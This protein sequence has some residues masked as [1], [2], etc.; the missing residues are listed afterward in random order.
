MGKIKKSHIL[1]VENTPHTSKGQDSVLKKYGYK[2]TAVADGKE[3][4]TIVKNKSNQVDL[5]LIDLDL[6]DDIDGPETARR[7]LKEEML[8]IVF[9][10]DC[11][12]KET[13]D[14]VKDITNY[15]YILK[16]SGEFVLMESINMAFRLSKAHQCAME[17][18]EKL[19]TIFNETPDVI[20]IHDL[21]SRIHEVNQTAADVYQY[22][23]EEL[24]SMHIE[25]LDPD[26]KE[27]EDGGRFWDSVDYK[28]PYQFEARQK[29]KDGTIFPAE[30]RVTKLKLKGSTYIMAL[31]R[32][33]SDRK[34]TEEQLRIFRKVVL[35]VHDPIAVI[36]TSY[37]YIL[38]NPVYSRWLDLDKNDIIGRKVPEILGKELFETEL[39]EYIDE[40]FTGSV[41]HYSRWFKFPIKGEVYVDVYYYPFRDTD[42]NITALVIVIRDITGQKKAEEELK[43]SLIE[44]EAL[45]KEMNHRVKNNLAM[46]SSLIRLKETAVGN[47]TDFSDIRNQIDAILLI[48][49]KLFLHEV[50]TTIEFSSYI[51]ELLKTVFDSFSAQHV[52]IENNISNVTLPAKKAVPLG[53]IINEVATNAIKHGFEAGENARFY[54]EMKTQKK[55]TYTLIIGNS[56]RPLPEHI[57]IYNTETLGL[58]LISALTEQLDAEIQIKSRPSPEFCITFPL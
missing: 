11:T 33:I 35:T 45:L 39:K 2:V 32:D 58:Q 37:T 27:R 16:S 34:K 38:V 54:I 22:S 57:D 7:I 51:D 53:L 42:G 48:H 28:K 56:G 18:E 19:L 21:D 13:A 41:V 9:L 3:A 1:L 44:R 40:C 52:K 43:Q 29:R 46:V 25:D 36:D 23:R 5:V 30:V 20:I 55:D 6:H 8:P 47:S 4:V 15:G 50:G 31:S 10:T 49:E 12:E 26:Y 24:L 17:Q 14:R